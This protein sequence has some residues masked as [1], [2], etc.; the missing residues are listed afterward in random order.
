MDTLLTTRSRKIAGLIALF[1]FFVAGMICS[2]AFGVTNIS[3]RTIL[4]SYTEFNGSQEHLIIQNARMPRAFIAAA[5]GA[6]LAVA[7]AL[8]QGITRNQLASPSLFGI[9]AG[10]AFFIVV[11]SAFFGASGMSAF[12]TL[13]FIGAAFTSILVYVLG[14]IGNDGLTPLKVTL[15][16]AALTAFFSSLSLGVLLTGGQTFDQVLYWFVGSVAGRDMNIFSAAAPFTAIALIGALFLARHM[17]VLALGE[18]VAVGL[19]QKTI[20]I[21][22]AAGII[23]VLLAGGSVSM[24]GPIAFVGII[25]PHLTRYLVGIDYRWII[26]YCAVL[27]SILLLAADIGSR[28]IL[29]PKEVPIGVM[30]AIIGVPFFVYIARK[31]GGTLN[32]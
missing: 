17:N 18:D 31:G 22:L 10:A 1:L 27:G 21:K 14:S 11:G 20:Y 29:F 3:W 7:G 26:P 23:I 32:E 13:A 16:G 24:A 15:A 8:M 19:G 25:V 9:N 2:I 4:L 6:S 28:Y 5:A 12:A 30:T